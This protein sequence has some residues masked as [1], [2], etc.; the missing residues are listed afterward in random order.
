MIKKWA[1]AFECDLSKGVCILARKDAGE[2]DVALFYSKE[3]AEEW[4]NSSGEID[5]KLWDINYI[6]IID[7]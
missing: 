6:R 1:V 3:E 5:A 7:I 2:G 4:V